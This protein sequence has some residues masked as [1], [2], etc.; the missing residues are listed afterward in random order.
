A[1]AKQKIEELQPDVVFLDIR[2]PSGAEGFDL[3]QQIANPTF[4]VVF[5]TAFKDYA[6]R[7]FQANAIHYIL[8]PIDIED[9]QKAEQKLL[10]YHHRFQEDQTSF[11]QYI[12]GMK[13]VPETLSPT[14]L[15]R[16]AVPHSKGFV[17]VNVEEIVHFVGDDGYTRLHLQSG[18]ELVT[19]ETMKTY[20]ELLVNNDFV[21]IHK[22][23]LINLAFLKE[24]VSY[25]GNF[26]VLT[27]GDELPISRTR[28]RAFLNAVK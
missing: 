8:K 13:Q 18:Q 6:V 21:R 24:Y 28:L 22:S 19:S 23:H 10:D 2:M 4:Q 9:L 11:D 16:L 12:Q 25:Q 26:A 5:V 3:I 1:I 17:M 20:E 14:P 27:N 15:K 7:A